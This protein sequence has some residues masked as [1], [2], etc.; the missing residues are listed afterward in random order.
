MPFKNNKNIPGKDAAAGQGAVGL[1]RLHLNPV[2][3][4][5]TASGFVSRAFPSALAAFVFSTV[6]PLFL[7]SCVSMPVFAAMLVAALATGALL[8]ALY[9]NK[10]IR[11][12]L[13]IIACALAAGC[14]VLAVALPDARESVFALVNAVVYRIDD[15][16]G[17][18]ISL[19]S[20]GATVC[21]S[22][23]FGV[24][25]GILWGVASFALTR[26]RSAVL[27]FAVA[28][29]IG[30]VA[31]VLD[32]GLCVAGVAAGVAGWV[33]HARLIQ[34]YH[35]RYFMPV[36]VLEGVIALA[37]AMAIAVACGVL[38][39]PLQA[40]DDVHEAV[41]QAIDEARYGHDTLPQ[42]ELSQAPYMNDGEDERIQLSAS[43][44]VYDDLLLKGFIGGDFA[45]GT[46]KALDHTAYEGKWAGVMRW[47][48]SEGLVPTEQRSAYDDERI[49]AGADPIE[50]AH[51]EL[52]A[53]DANRRYVYVP[54]TLRS[55]DDV[56]ANQ[57]LDG[58]V[59][60]GFIG[61]RSYSYD[62]D[63]I[64]AGEVLASTEWLEGVSSSYT[65]AE[66]VLAAFAKENY[67]AISK[68]EKKA[69]NELIFNSATWDKSAATSKYAVISRVRTMLSTMAS[70]TESPQALPSKEKSFARWFLS[71][72]REGNSAYFATAAT[73][74]FRA[75]GIPARYVEGYRA[76]A[77]ELDAAVADNGGKLSLT[78][79]DA[80]AWVEVYMDGLGWTPVEVTAGFYT[81]KVDADSVISVREAQSS[82]KG[83]EVLQ[84]ESVA[85]E[86]DPQDDQREQS[87]LSPVKV[88]VEALLIVLA[89]LLIAAL[90]LLV[91]RF[92]RIARRKKLIESE[93]QAVSVPALY[94][95]LAAVMGASKVPFDATKPLDAIDVFAGVF[96]DIDPLEYKR[97][98]AIHQSYAFGARK[99]RPNEMRTIRRFAERLHAALP[100]PQTVRERL[101]RRF[102]DAL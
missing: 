56:N 92:L 91:E 46:W 100:K 40:V 61:D 3:D 85:G 20:S 76:S 10:G 57:D 4:G 63:N 33:C 87:T 21:G 95:Y 30:S 99:L 6:L 45:D 22:V 79:K 54:Y 19:V 7:A 43:S 18:Y 25:L 88:A 34:L 60:G 93:D 89:L 50:T 58:A 36:Y 49:R 2:S 8:G 71:D 51:I 72:A 98:I 66:A 26:R 14:V 37:A 52:D 9:A 31:I 29:A 65:Q 90:V 86:Y 84:G 53:K 64:A 59:T 15:V 35:G 44:A 97:A 16:F 75:Q 11:D 41:H 32:T 1:G 77:K 38:Y 23:V 17:L 83:S 24:A 102:V 27:T 62:I 78:S 13:G 81:Q 28:I 68:E 70:Y 67:T 12:A 5:L 82:G 47:L 96:A 69:V 39:A 42:G 55:L 74:A 94:S 48:R 101:K 73:L 80:H